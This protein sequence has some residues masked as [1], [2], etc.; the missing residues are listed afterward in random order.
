M[1]NK[2]D[3]L[4]TLSALKKELN[5]RDNEGSSGEMSLNACSVLTNALEQLLEI[6]DQESKPQSTKEV[7]AEFAHN[8]NTKLINLEKQNED[9]AKAG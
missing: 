5:Q 3:L 8:V 9:L 4:D 7:S 2:E 6:M 1:A